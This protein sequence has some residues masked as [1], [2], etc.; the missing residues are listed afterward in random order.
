MK[1]ATIRRNGEERLVVIH[2]SDRQAFDLADAAARD[3]RPNAAFE[4]MLALI[5]ADDETSSSV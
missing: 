3:G 1:L 2:S 4:S 5:D